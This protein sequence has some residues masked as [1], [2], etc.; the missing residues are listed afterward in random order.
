MSLQSRGRPRKSVALSVNESIDS[1]VQES[2]SPRPR[3]R[4]KKDVAHS[5][6]ESLQ[7]SQSLSERHDEGEN[8][9]SIFDSELVLL[10]PTNNEAISDLVSGKRIRKPRVVFDP[11]E[12][13]QPKKDNRGRRKGP[14]HNV[15]EAINQA[16]RN[17]W[18]EFIDKISKEVNNLLREMHY[19]ETFTQ[20]SYGKITDM[21]SLDN[22]I[23]S[24]KLAIINTLKEI[25]AKNQDHIRWPELQSTNESSS[26]DVENIFCSLCQGEATDDNDILLC[27]RINCYRAYHQNCL[28]PPIKAANIDPKMDWFCWQCECFDTSLDII[29]EKTGVEGLTIEDVFPEVQINDFSE[30]LLSNLEFMEDEDEEDEDY[31]PSVEG[32]D[33]VFESDEEDQEDKDNLAS[34]ENS[35]IS[36]KNNELNEDGNDDDDDDDDDEEDSE[37]S[38]DE[39]GSSE[40]DIDNDELQGL[41]A[42]ADL[43]INIVE[44]SR[45]GR[46]LRSQK[47]P[48]EFI[49]LEGEKDIGKSIARI[50]RGV[51]HIGKIVKF[52]PS[53]ESTE[54][55]IDGIWT[56]SFDDITEEEL[57]QEEIR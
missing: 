36:N 22:K 24:A 49:Q 17:I 46:K 6:N 11:F 1:S 28:D 41:L 56:I 34:N 29:G 51:Y 2:Q 8:S 45:S 9:N 27:D 39:E 25:Q 57:T 40:E 50:I 15:N 44:L 43:D 47:Q 23:I 26:V 20:S 55:N 5:V 3:G 31:D 7:G 37:G 42:D 35:K 33:E 13:N 52:T 12:M 19:Q 14:K 4:P 53:T 54:E 38:D 10:S 16:D 48:E 21:R 30:N 32:N 18:K